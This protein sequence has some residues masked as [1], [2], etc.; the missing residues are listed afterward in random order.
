MVRLSAGHARALIAWWPER[1]AASHSRGTMVS[2]AAS[3]TLFQYSNGGRRR[4]KSESAD[5]HAG[6]TF[7]SRLNTHSSTEPSTMR[8]SIDLQRR[9]A[10]RPSAQP[11]ARTA[12][13]ASV[14]LASN[15]ESEGISDQAIESPVNA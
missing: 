5:S 7:V 14:R 1:R 15:H 12:P 9:G 10:S 13:Y 6:N 8:L 2:A 4:A 11:P 3:P